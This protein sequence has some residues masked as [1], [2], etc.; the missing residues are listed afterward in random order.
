MGGLKWT[1]SGYDEEWLEAHIPRYR[2]LLGQP[3]VKNEELKAFRKEVVASYHKKFPGH[4]DTMSLG[5]LKLGGSKEERGKRFEDVS[6]KFT[7]YMQWFCSPLFSAAC[8][9]L[10]L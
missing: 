6:P 3:R 10:V 8:Q 5:K 7:A 9:G 4:I 1:I 2:E